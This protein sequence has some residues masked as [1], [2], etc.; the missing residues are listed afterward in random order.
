MSNDLVNSFII[1]FDHLGLTKE[2]GEDCSGIEFDH[3]LFQSVLYNI[4]GD[5]YEYEASDGE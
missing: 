3:T 5:N 1:I 2:P 4:Y